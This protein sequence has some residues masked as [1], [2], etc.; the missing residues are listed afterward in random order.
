[1]RLCPSFPL[2]LGGRKELAQ[3]SQRAEQAEGGRAF[4][5][6]GRMNE[7][8]RNARGRWTLPKP[9]TASRPRTGWLRE[10]RKATRGP[11]GRGS[12]TWMSPR[13][14]RAEAG[15]SPFPNPRG[16]SR[17]TEVRPHLSC[18]GQDSLLEEPR[19]C[20]PHPLAAGAHWPLAARALASLEDPGPLPCRGA[21][22]M[23][24]TL[25]SPG[26]ARPG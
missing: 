8:G 16:Y 9:V 15:G 3:A 6:G 19:H 2:G 12:L 5:L 11:L 17:Q 10:R 24:Q 21:Q 4:Y 26:L 23:G 14:W 13:C 22:A 25:R 7:G 18:W 1:M 20:P